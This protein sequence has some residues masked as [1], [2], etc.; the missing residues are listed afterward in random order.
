MEG[1]R[2]LNARQQE[3]LDYINANGN[4]NIR[5]FIGVHDVSEATIRR[6]FDELSKLGLID[7]VHGGAVRVNSTTFER[8]HSEKM[9]LMLG[10]KMRIAAYAASLVKN[11]DS[12]FLDSGTTAYFIARELSHHKDLVII[13]NSL[14]IVQS[15]QF[16]PTVS[17]I[18][19]GGVRREQYNALVGSIAEQIISS[20][21]V[22]KAFMGCDAIDPE[23][24]VYN[25]NFLAV[26]VKQCITR[27]GKKTILVADSSKF[28]VKALAK[29]CDLQHID[30][31]I[32]DN[33]L[34]D[35]TVQ[36]VRKCVP[37]TICV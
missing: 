31:I 29:V 22:D 34:D 37:N 18:V 25:T 28:Y 20:F 4:A 1:N 10:E 12:V 15:V 3:I 17:L 30:M 8:F 14:D 13:T 27:C 35:K 23:S 9:S 36:A 5:E 16:D 2:A 26:G 11:G 32:T 6:D 24:G 19:T 21:C 33:G 7:R